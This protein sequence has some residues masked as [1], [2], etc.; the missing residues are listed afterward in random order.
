M[1]RKL[2]VIGLAVL[3]VLSV[4]PRTADA[5]EQILGPWLWMIAP[6]EEGQGGAASTDI[7]LL[8]VASDNKVTEEMVAKNGANEGDTVGDYQ[9]TLA[10]L[11]ADGNINTVVNSTGMEEGDD[12]NHITS[13][14]LYTYNSD[15]AQE[16]TMKTGSDDSIK[17]WLN[18]EVVFTNAVNRGRGMWQD[19]FGISLKQGDNFLMVKI[20][21]AG[22]GWGMHVGILEEPY[23]PIVDILTNWLWMIARP[24]EGQ[25]GAAATDVDLLAAASKD[26]VT[27]EM[28]AMLGAAEG[29][30][31][32]DYDW[33]LAELPQDG[34]LDPIATL[35]EVEGAFDHITAYGLVTLVSDEAKEVTL[36]A[37]SDDSIKV[38]LNGENV[39]T[40]AVNRGRGRWQDEFTV[41]LKQGDNILLVK[42]S[43]AG[44]GWGMHFGIRGEIESAYKSPA[45]LGTSVEPKDKFITTWG[46]LKGAK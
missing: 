4:I 45:E 43:D 3:L 38:W 32:G 22:G 13:Y 16:A 46:K 27:E 23:V 10:E 7:D 8:A 39:H 36:L 40:N 44:G 29:D 12:L 5:Q 28:I 41:N 21:E 1:Y 14:A 17:V 19:E 31:V 24:E 42:V 20:C 30:S 11:P 15:K 25:G 6:A 33:T 2:F 34:N 26:A 18:G 37:G 35:M 9:W